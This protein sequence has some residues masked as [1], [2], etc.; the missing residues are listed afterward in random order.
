VA[1]LSIGGGVIGGG[2]DSE[3][4]LSFGGGVKA[5]IAESAAIRVEYR[6]DRIFLDFADMDQHRMM[7][8]VS[9]FLGG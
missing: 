5:F 9:G 2:E 3:F 6:Y 7:F 4:I 1:F 8:G